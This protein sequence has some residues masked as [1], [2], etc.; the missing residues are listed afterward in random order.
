MAGRDRPHHRYPELQ[1]ADIIN[2][3]VFLA[4]TV[5]YDD[6]QEYL[7]RPDS[8]V[9]YGRHGNPTTNELNRAITE[10][11]HGYGSVLFPSGL[12]AAALT[13]LA[14]ARPNDRFLIADNIYYPTKL[15]CE[16]QLT[17]LGVEVS[18]FDPLNLDDLEE[19][20]VS[21][22]K[23]LFLEPVGSLTLE[24]SDIVTIAAMAERH[25]AI[26]IADNTWGSG[27]LINPLDLGFDV[28]V[29]SCSKFF[30]GHS[31]IIMGAAVATEAAFG[32]IK[33]FSTAVGNLAGAFDSYLILRGIRTLR[34]R[35]SQQSSSAQ[36]IATW[37]RDNAAFSVAYPLFDKSYRKECGYCCPEVGGSLVSLSLPRSCQSQLQGFFERLTSFRIGFSWGGFESLALCADLGQKRHLKGRQTPENELIVRFHVG[38]QDPAMLI[39]ELEQGLQVLDHLSRRNP[40]S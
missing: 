12:N 4:S 24:V 18:L 34:P 22:A 9:S 23:L 19:K 2:P 35:L 32:V 20:L 25:G 13:L 3:P 6:Y 38:L 11:E 17:S 15:F 37:L 29:H 14:Y 33:A 36:Q 8:K 31:D 39:S 26:C 10:L 7:E 1:P 27:I 16:K 40:G 28:S 30:C 5:L 21:G